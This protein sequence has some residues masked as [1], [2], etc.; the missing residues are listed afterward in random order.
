MTA[1]S[2]NDYEVIRMVAGSSGAS[3]DEARMEIENGLV[4][5]GMNYENARALLALFQV[6]AIEEGIVE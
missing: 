5:G 3:L 6:L 1:L 4:E 2:R